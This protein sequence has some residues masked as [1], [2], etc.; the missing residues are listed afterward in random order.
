MTE[1]RFAFQAKKEP[2]FTTTSAITEPK[3]FTNSS[4][5]LEGAVEFEMEW[6]N[7]PAYLHDIPEEDWKIE[8]AFLLPSIVVATVKLSRQQVI[9]MMRLVVHLTLAIYQINTDKILTSCWSSFRCYL[10][11]EKGCWTHTWDTPSD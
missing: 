7:F 8:D 10:M 9:I 5:L 1:L 2:T 11:G 4:F 6:D 3:H